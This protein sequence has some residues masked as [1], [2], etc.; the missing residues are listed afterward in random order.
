M[1]T[2]Q[3]KPVAAATSEPPV[4]RLARSMGK[5]FLL[6]GVIIAV[7]AAAATA[8]AGLEKVSDIADRL[9]PRSHQFGGPRGLVVPDYSGGP[10]TFLLIGSDRRPLSHDTVDRAN[11]PHSDTLLLVRFDPNQGQTSVLSIPRD[12]MVSITLPN[13]AVAAPVAKINEAYTLGPEYI[14]NH[15]PGATLAAYTVKRLLGIRLNAIVD[16][17]FS[18]FLQ[19]VGKLGCVYINVDRR[20]YIP[21]NTGVATID[22]QPGYQK[23]CYTNALDYVRFRHFDSDFVR[24]ARQQS[25]LRA[26]REQIS[27]ATLANHLD[28]V[29]STIGQAM[30][31]SGLDTDPGH[32]ISLLQ[33]LGFSQSKPLRQVKFAISSETAGGTAKAPGTYVTATPTQIQQTVADFLHGDQHLTVPASSVSSQGH[34]RASHHRRTLAQSAAAAGLYPIASGDRSQV[35]AAGPGVPFPIEFPAYQTS[36]AQLQEVHVYRASDRD[37]RPYT[38]YIGVFEVNGDGGY[39]DVNGMTWTDP[40]FTRNPSASFALSGRRYWVV[41]DGGQVNLVYWRQHGVLYWINNT[42][43]EDLSNAQMID[44]ARSM[45]RVH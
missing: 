6:A 30:Y 27:V 29:A 12:L 31:T 25:F 14:H 24:V 42:L 7:L 37:G 11:A 8:T 17:T 32:L 13:G 34:A 3:D 4:P 1:S 5:R 9:F 40:P 2:V 44:L 21:P 15:D 43:L 35:F 20:Y 18:G 16:T 36:T 38:G 28:S 22:L 23:L 26:A 33:L 41:S 45:Q 19:V 10:E 39:Y